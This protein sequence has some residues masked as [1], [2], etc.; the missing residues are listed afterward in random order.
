MITTGF[1]GHSSWYSLPIPFPSPPNPNTLKIYTNVHPPQLLTTSLLTL[2]FLTTTLILHA[3][4]TLNPL[5]NTSL[6]ALLTLLWTLSFSLLT[7]WSAGTLGHVC[8]TL[9]WD[10]NTG[11]MV[12]RIYKALF[13]FALLG[14][15]STALALGLDVRTMK[16]V[17]RRGKFAPLQQREDK[18]RGGLED[19]GEELNPNPTRRGIKGNRG[20]EGYAVPEEQFAYQDDTSYQGAAGQVERR[21]L[22]ARL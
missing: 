3:L 8:N 15:L 5:L 1:R 14:F 20:G 6:N 16:Q 4:H 7:W 11:I 2:V 17:G 10:T 19:V 12:C 18:T 21:S 9:N 22:E 13:S